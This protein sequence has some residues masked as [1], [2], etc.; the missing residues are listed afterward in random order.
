M[1][2]PFW[3]G[4]R[5]NARHAIFPSYYGSVWFRMINT[6][7]RSPRLPLTCASVH[8]KKAQQAK[9][10]LAFKALAKLGNFGNVQVFLISF[11]DFG[12]GYVAYTI[13][14]CL[15]SPGQVT[16]VFLSQCETRKKNLIALKTDAQMR[17]LRSVCIDMV[18]GCQLTNHKVLSSL[19]PSAINTT[20]SD[21]QLI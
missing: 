3:P 7:F 4:I 1:N 15:L 12:H 11:V 10:Y 14:S 21:A 20:H 8:R 6:C 17:Q 16:I 18:I 5:K 13:Y 19:N 2:F 9:L